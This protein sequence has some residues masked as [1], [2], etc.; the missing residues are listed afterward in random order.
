M[1][2]VLRMAETI[3]PAVVTVVDP[4]DAK[5]ATQLGQIAGAATPDPSAV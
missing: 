4:G 3:G 2:T 5:L 1:L